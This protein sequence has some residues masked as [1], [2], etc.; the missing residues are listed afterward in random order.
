MIALAL[1]G[2]GA[3]KYFNYLKLFII[4]ILNSKR[5]TIAYRVIS[6]IENSPVQRVAQVM[7]EK[8]LNEY[9]PGPVI[10]GQD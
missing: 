9:A 7:Q 3:G 8:D 2:F 5:Q 1:S 4:I 6:N 10:I